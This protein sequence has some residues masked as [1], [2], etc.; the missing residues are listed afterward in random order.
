M[1]VVDR[2]PP[3]GSF[4]L[5]EEI[6]GLPGGTTLNSAVTL[7]RLGAKVSLVSV[8]AH[9]NYGMKILEALDREDIDRHW[10]S[11]REG[12]RTDRSLIVVSREEQERTIFCQQ[13]L[14]LKKGDPL[15]IAAIFGHDLVIL[16]VD[17]MSLRQFLVDLPAH[18]RPATRLLGP[19]TYL[20]DSGEA[21][22]W[23]IALRHDVI[24]GNERELLTLTG[25]TSL[26]EGLEIALGSMSGANLRACV[27]S[28][29][30]Q[31]AVAVT[32][33][34]RWDAP[35]TEVETVDTTGA[36]DAFAGAIAYATALRWDWERALRFA[37]ALAALSTRGLG[38]ITSLPSI[39]EV[40]SILKVEPTTLMP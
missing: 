27:V 9:D 32:K 33:S 2:Y 10:L 5:T 23:E 38:G 16:D 26:D 30:S 40:A 20:A 7:A 3:L 22:A 1:V 14:T 13:N 35:A 28:R 4:S 6:V 31:G 36:G 8:V 25:A 19:M 37:N 21:G 17:D 39:S 12:E 18:T 24:V 29:G 34:G 11:L 15:D